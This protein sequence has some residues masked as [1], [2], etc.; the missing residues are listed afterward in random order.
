MR[1]KYL[2]PDAAGKMLGKSGE[3]IRNLL[4]KGDLPGTKL[5]RLWYIPESELYRRLKLQQK[6]IQKYGRGA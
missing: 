2:T 3:S 4:R 6:Y 1:E 5:G